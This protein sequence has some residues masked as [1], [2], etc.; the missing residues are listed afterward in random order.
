MAIHISRHSQQSVQTSEYCKPF[1]K[2]FLEM[3][4]SQRV[5]KESIPSISTV[6]FALI[7]AFW[8]YECTYVGAIKEIWQTANMVQDL[9]PTYYFNICQTM[10]FLG[11]TILEQFW[12]P[13]VP[14]EKKRKDETKHVA[15]TVSQQEII[16][17]KNVICLL[18]ER[19][20]VKI[21]KTWYRWWQPSFC[22]HSS[23]SSS[24]VFVSIF[25]SC[26]RESWM[27]LRRSGV[28]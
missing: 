28:G 27:W 23:S 21:R 18:I 10:E 7:T 6:L 3:I 19:A 5:S 15:V 2:I 1:L 25:P 17:G 11:L 24:V 20:M 12:G 8:K 14:T 4:L 16:N 9:F 22:S 26:G 13:V